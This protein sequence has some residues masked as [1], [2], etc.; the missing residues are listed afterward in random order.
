MPIYGSES[1]YFP[2]GIMVKFTVTDTAISWKTSKPA[3]ADSYGADS[4]GSDVPKYIWNNNYTYQYVAF[5]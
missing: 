3:K 5:G 1:G 4:Y 2:Q